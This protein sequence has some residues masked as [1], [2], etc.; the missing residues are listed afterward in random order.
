MLV[1]ISTLI[2]FVLFFAYKFFTKQNEIFKQ[3]GVAFEKP[4]FFFGN[5]FVDLIMGTEGEPTIFKHLYERFSR[6]K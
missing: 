3:R 5:M 2:A 6:E 4:T 1:A